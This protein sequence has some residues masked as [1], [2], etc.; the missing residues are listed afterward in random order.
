MARDNASLSHMLS[1]RVVCSFRG[2]AFDV[3]RPVG[4]ASVQAVVKRLF[5]SLGYRSSRRKQLWR[6][7]LS[8]GT[9][10]KT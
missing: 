4:F 5:R 10:L 6:R 3:D 7:V 9:K 1:F 8:V 2:Q